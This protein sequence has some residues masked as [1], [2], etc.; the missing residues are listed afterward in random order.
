MSPRPASGSGAGKPA[1]NEAVDFCRGLGLWMLFVDHFKPNFWSHFTLGHFGFSDF[2]EIFIFLSGFINAGMYR[3]ALD[4]GGLA[5]ATRKLGA[6]MVRLY[7]AHIASLVAS[8]AV[9]AA[10]E[11]GGLLLD[12]P[13]LYVWM[14]APARYA[15]QMLALLYAPKWFGL[16]PL[17]I[18]L[19]PFMLL[20]VISMRRRPVVTLSASCAV[21]CIAQS[22]AFDLP[23]TAVP[24][25][26]HFRP[27]AWQFLFAI[28]ASAETYWE[29]IGRVARSRIVQA[30]AAA[31]V[32][33]SLAVKTAA[34]F[35]PARSRIFALTPA[36]IPLLY[37]DAG[38][39]SLAPYRLVHFLSLAVLAIAIPWNPRRALQFSVVRVAVG[40]G[41]DSLLIFCVTLVLTTGGS[42]LLE[43][44]AAGKLLQLVF[45]ALGV[46]VICAIAYARGK[47]PARI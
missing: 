16:L 8:L 25:A 4:T 2:A 31:V 22:N 3:R 29:A 37:D 12:E 13:E 11:A 33:A 26:W 47:V 28:G 42:L 44:Y 39:S 10:F 17:Y 34:A 14:D 15:L 1:R 6:R 45:S 32:L 30:G 41:R 21:W 36:L 7:A 24:G 40:V 35:G 18:I 27:L 38:K 20:A 43:N 9:L 23:I 19:A 46:A 5:S